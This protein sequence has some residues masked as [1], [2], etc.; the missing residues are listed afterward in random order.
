MK[1]AMAAF[2][3]ASITR[4]GTATGP[5][6]LKFAGVM[7]VVMIYALILFVSYINIAMKGIYVFKDSS[8]FY[9]DFINIF[10][11]AKISGFSIFT[12]FI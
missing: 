7:F 1:N 10:A 9:L 12:T 2:K 6:V 3:T 4:T 8:Y 11:V 5:R